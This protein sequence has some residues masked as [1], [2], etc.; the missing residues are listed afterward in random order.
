MWMWLRVKSIGIFV[1]LDNHQFDELHLIE[2]IRVTI[3]L[4]PCLSWD[5]LVYAFSPSILSGLAFDS[6]YLFLKEVLL[7]LFA[8]K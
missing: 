8:F 1:F 4:K 5:S 6:D 3:S 7:S 2:N